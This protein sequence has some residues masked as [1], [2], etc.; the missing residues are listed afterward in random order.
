MKI[1]IQEEAYNFYEKEFN[2]KNKKKRHDSD[3][4]SQ[5][6]QLGLAREELRRVQNERCPYSSSNVLGGPAFQWCLEH[7]ERIEICERNIADIKAKMK[8]LTQK[9]R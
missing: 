8:E 4:L 3:L 2:T 6:R 9:Q 7:D 5:K 1:N